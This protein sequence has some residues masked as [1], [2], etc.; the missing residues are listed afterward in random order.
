MNKINEVCKLLGVEVGEVFTTKDLE[1]SYEYKI[2]EDGSVW[3]CKNN[4]FWVEALGTYLNLIDFL[5]GGI[6]IIK[7]P[8]K[9]NRGDKYWSV[10]EDRCIYSKCWDGSFVDI[11]HYKIGN[12]F[13]T[14]EE[15]TQE[16]IDKFVKFFNSNKQIDIGKE[17]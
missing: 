6:E 5:N 10:Y 8:F 14:K 15:I 2:L 12:C 13:K 4:N 3:Y 17:K 11:I 1:Y 9:P 16:T 7:K